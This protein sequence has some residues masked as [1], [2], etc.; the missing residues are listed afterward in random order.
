[1]YKYGRILMLKPKR[2]KNNRNKRGAINANKNM[3]LSKKAKNILEDKKTVYFALTIILLYTAIYSI[4]NATGPSNFGD[5]VAYAGLANQIATGTFHESSYIFS[6]RILQVYP[7]AFFYWLLG[8]NIYT[9]Q[10][11][12]SL[13]FVLTIVITFYIG[14]EIYSEYAGLLAAFLMSFFP[15]SVV[16]AMTMSDNIPMM[17]F[18]SAAMLALIKAEKRKSRF[19]YFV[20]APFALASFLVTPEGGIIGVVI[21]A[22]LAVEIF[23]KKI[24]VDRIFLFF[25]YGIIVFMFLLLL[26]NYW[27]SGNPFISITGTAHF[28]SAVG[29]QNTI[30]STDT[31]LSFYFNIMFPYTPQVMFG[32]IYDML[33]NQNTVGFYFYALAASLVYLAIRKEKRAYFPAF[34]FFAGFLYLE[35]GPMHI[36][37]NPLQYLLMYRIDRYLNLVAVPVALLIAIAITRSVGNIKKINGKTLAALE[38]SALSLLFIIGTALLIDR[39]WSSIMYA[40]RYDQVQIAQ[41]LS[42]LPNT[43]KIYYVNGLSDVMIYNGF[44][45]MSRYHNY[46]D[47]PNCSDLPVG[48]YVIVPKYATFDNLNYTP[49]PNEYCSGWSIALDPGVPPGISQLVNGSSSHFYAWLYYVQSNS[50][51]K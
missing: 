41:Y 30:P 44:S 27:N 10:A 39:R 13:S 34:W 7:I 49:D 2:I 1:M 22:Y 29:G 14:K 36:S 40:Q 31:N 45:N 3:A 51:S 32:G 19:W 48:A 50:T 24:K 6:L 38:V 23:R 12:D 46:A 15:I 42:A 17:L 11:W 47:M 33:S 9:S 37:I 35:M 43:T 20:L 28:F 16:Y 25:F 8:A 5:D 18:A 21:V 4:L 26:F